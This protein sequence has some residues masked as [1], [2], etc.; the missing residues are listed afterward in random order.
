MIGR[1]LR[2]MRKDSNLSQKQLA[3]MLKIDQTTLSGWERG[4]R[5][6]I[7]ES[8]EEIAKLCGYEITFKSIKTKEELTT[9]NIFRKE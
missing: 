6:P 3:Y 8:I 2:K 9:K 1:I 7:F 5:E 4:Y